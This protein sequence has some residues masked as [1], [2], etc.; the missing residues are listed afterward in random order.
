MIWFYIAGFVSGVVGTLLLGKHISRK[1]EEG[2]L[3]NEQDKLH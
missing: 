3:N 2:I 1:M